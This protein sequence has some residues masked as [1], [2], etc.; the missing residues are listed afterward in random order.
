MRFVIIVLLLSVLAGCTPSP[1]SAEEIPNKTGSLVWS[2]GTVV[3][4]KFDEGSNKVVYVYKTRQAFD[5]AQKFIKAT[6]DFGYNQINQSSQAIKVAPGTHAKILKQ[7]P[8]DSAVEVR[9]TDG[10]S[11]NESG[12]VHTVYMHSD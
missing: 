3:S 12:F 10:K 5:D 9:I 11:S 8:A 2:E 6:D 4:L 1:P 7:S